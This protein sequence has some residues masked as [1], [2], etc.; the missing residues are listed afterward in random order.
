MNFLK[1][2]LSALFFSL[3]LLSCSKAGYKFKINTPKKTVFGEKVS[4]SF[5]Q[6]NGGKVDSV[7]LFVNN[8]RLPLNN[9][10]AVINTSDF[11]VGQHKITALAF[12]PNKVKKIN[13]F[14]EV[15][16]NKS[17]VVYT[18]K[19]TNVYPHDTKAFTQG[20]EYHNGFIYETTGRKGKSW[21]RKVDYKTGE[22]LQ[23][24]N[25]D[26]KYFGE[27]MT[28]LN[29]K[30]YW[31]TWQFG[32]GFI[33]NLSNFKQ[34]KSFKYSKSIEG[35]GLTN[36]G[37]NLIKSDG[38]NKL[39]FLNP[40]NLSEESVIQAYTDK[41]KIDRLNELEWVDGKI[42]ANRWITEKPIKSI[43]VIINPENGIV[44][45]LINLNGLRE[46][47]LKTQK[48]VDQDEVLNG[49]A[50]DAKNKRMFV[51]GKHWNKLFEIEIV[52]KQ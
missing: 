16:A 22:I 51:T 29:D 42:Y 20:L 43:I 36:N 49:I 32:E 37:R 24:E 46:E 4:V 28:I 19:I 48:L 25:L 34:I 8:K 10:Q 27:G 6:T 14:I 1:Y 47:V 35:W 11:G 5:E 3:A 38:T 39:W 31:L 23:Q 13:S 15:F 30:I 17:P 2:T 44:E 12:V 26:E 41:Y 40:E 33:Y 52:K 9:N 18:Y 45:G 7:H 21:L 50:Y